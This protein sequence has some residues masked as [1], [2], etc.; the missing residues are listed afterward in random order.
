MDTAASAVLSVWHYPMESFACQCGVELG[1]FLAQPCSV[2][3]GTQS[4]SGKLKQQLKRAQQEPFFDAHVVPTSGDTLN[5]QWTLDYPVDLK[6]GVEV[7]FSTL[8]SALHTK[9]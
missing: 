6:K 1:R 5:L 4:A 9:V 8:K 3:F 7:C 2:G